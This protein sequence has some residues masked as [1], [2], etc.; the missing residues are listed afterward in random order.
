VSKLREFEGYY[1]VILC[2]KGH[3]KILPII[4]RYT[5]TSIVMYPDAMLSCE[6]AA[7][8][9]ICCQHEG[10]QCS[11]HEGNKFSFEKRKIVYA[12]GQWLF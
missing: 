7:N 4:N 6:I 11:C 10:L 8:H 2:E 1:R 12:E 3:I 5:T 9:G